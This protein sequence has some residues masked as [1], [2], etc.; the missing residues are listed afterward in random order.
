MRKRLGIPSAVTT[1]GGWSDRDLTTS[2]RAFLPDASIASRTAFTASST[3]RREEKLK[4]AAPP[5]AKRGRETRVAKTRRKI[6]VASNGTPPVA[7]SPPH[8]G[9]AR[10]PPA[11]QTNAQA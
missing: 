2:T 7:A 3:D 4:L 9:P 11:S 8:A 10:G 5:R 1:R 6:A